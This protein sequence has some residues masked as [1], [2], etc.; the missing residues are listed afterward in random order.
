MALWD[1]RKGHSMFVQMSLIVF[2]KKK[3]KGILS[4]FFF[5]WRI[6]S[7]PGQPIVKSGLTF[8]FTLSRT[9]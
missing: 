4:D 5:R 7:N 1:L 2:R 6:I 8:A 9:N 3:Q